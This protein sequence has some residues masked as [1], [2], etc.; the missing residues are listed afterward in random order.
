MLKHIPLSDLELGMYVEKFDGGWFDHPFWKSKFLIEDESKL[1]VLKT[2]K[3]DGVIIDTSKGKDVSGKSRR[4]RIDK[5]GTVEESTARIG[6]IKARAAAQQ[7]PPQKAETDQEVHTAQAIAGKAKEQMQKLFLAARL[8]KAL[9][10]RLVEP[11][12]SDILNSVKRNPQAFG[13]LMRCKLRN[14]TV[15]QH[16]LAV[17]ALMVS[18]AGQMKLAE[19]KVREAGL[20]GLLLDVGTNY[21]PQNLEPANGDFRNLGRKIWDQHVMLGYRSLLDD[22][23]LPESVLE[24]VLKHHERIDGKGFPG[25]LPGEEIGQIARMA[26]I[27]DTFDHLLVATESSKALDP[28]SAI[29]K[30]KRMDGAFDPDIL[31][32]FI[33][34]IGLY[35]VGSF[36]RLRSERLAMVIDENPKDD[37]KPVVVAFYN[38]TTSERTREQKIV[39]AKPDCEDEIVEVADLSG[40]DLP[41]DS[42]LR[43]LMFMRAYNMD[44]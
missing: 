5:A 32:C 1:N 33:E 8:G 37:T 34:S 39:L 14:E 10:V 36:V 16:S 22:D 43:D 2:S 15:Y 42:Q 31:R 19:H 18:L 35:P 6:A 41:D 26:A 24:A 23:S 20:A 13:G 44:V 17:S 4:K 29:E 21:L 12:V 9:N 30:L 7:K 38:C 28:A 3:L 25:K 27:C 11:V 40:L